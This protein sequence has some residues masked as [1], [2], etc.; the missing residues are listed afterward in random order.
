MTFWTLLLSVAAYALACGGR[1]ERTAAALLVAAAAATVIVRSGAEQRYSSVETGILAV[2]ACLLMALVS[3]AVRSGR[4]WSIVLSVLQ[5]I[6]LLG[7]LGKRLDPE[8]WRLG[9]AMMITGPAYPGLA[10]LAIGIWQHRRATRS[11]SSTHSSARS[12]ST[13]RGP[14]R[15]GQPDN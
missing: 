4:R 5:G 14:I 11:M 3:L 9:Y 8:L 2:D 6:T 1:S 13:F 12:S 15:S 7:H 10:A